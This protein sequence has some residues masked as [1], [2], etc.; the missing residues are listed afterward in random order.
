MDIFNEDLLFASFRE[1]PIVPF[2][3]DPIYLSLYSLN[4]HLNACAAL[5]HRNL[6]VETLGV[7]VFT[8]P[9][10][11]Y[12]ILS[13]LLSVVPVNMGPTLTMT[14]PVPKAIV[15]SELF[16]NHAETLRVWQ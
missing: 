15:I 5:V 8:A 13:T 3:G 9:P 14:G 16:R 12:N 11:T 6:G 1:F 7:L 2:E 4:S 10:S